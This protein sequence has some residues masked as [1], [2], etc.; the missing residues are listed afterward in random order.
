MK[1]AKLTKA[2]RAKKSGQANKRAISN[3]SESSAA[4]V[5]KRKL[6]SNK[7]SSTPRKRA[8]PSEPAN[9]V[10]TRKARGKKDHDKKVRD[11]KVQATKVKTTKVQAAKVQKRQAK[12]VQIKDMQG[13]KGKR[14]MQKSSKIRASVVCNGSSTAPEETSSSKV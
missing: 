14:V 11:K 4:R 8:K 9:K 12:N 13:K 10:Q 3:A 7:D 2:L 5:L 1:R 6:N